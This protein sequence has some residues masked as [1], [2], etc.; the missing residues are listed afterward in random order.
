M[1]NPE[2][3]IGGTPDSFEVEFKGGRKALFAN[4]RNIP[5]CVGDHTVVDLDRGQDIGVVIREGQDAS[6][7][8][9][10]KGVLGPMLRRATAKDLAHLTELR[11]KEA[12]AHRI[13]QQCIA[14]QNLPMKL[15]DVEWQFDGNKIR[16]YF[17]SDH[18]VDFRKLV[19]DLAATF[20][21]RIEMRQIGVRDEARRL[22]GYG[23][24]GRYYCCRGVIH[25]FDPVTLKMV[26]EQ[27]LAPG[28]PKISG[29]CGRLMCCLRYER[30]FYAESV[31]EFPKLGT[32]VSL[33]GGGRGRVVA[34]DIFHRKVTV[35]D[36]EGKAIA[37]SIEDFQ[38]GRIG[39][40]E[41]SR[42][43]SQ[44][45]PFA[46][47]AELL[48]TVRSDGP[49]E[50]RDRRPPAD[51]GGAAAKSGGDEPRGPRTDA[52]GSVG[53]DAKDSGSGRR[54]AKDAGSGRR[55]AEDAGRG[56]REAKDAGQGKSEGKDATAGEQR[57]AST[58]PDGQRKSDRRRR[59]S[60]R[61]RRRRG[62]KRQSGGGGKGTDGK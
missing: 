38:A 53:R 1:T 14:K 33:S 24:C 42:D 29:G 36:D 22:G 16:F 20:K 23:R 48:G 58:T 15:V 43:R 47:P 57:G 26:K 5:F 30:D 44:D 39:A 41:S 25:D 59:S 49:S 12:E 4:P 13:C 19:R 28:S 8:M 34:V 9:K 35:S 51:G 3:I 46:I 10:E 62:G 52:G 54:E 32:K 55:D 27:H 60:G 31:R 61:S 40:R 37:V 45:D 56:R 50:R 2:G 18:R 21:T 7:A 17:T 11:E 6:D